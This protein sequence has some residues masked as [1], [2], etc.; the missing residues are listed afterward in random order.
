TR[1]KRDHGS[2]GNN[3][4]K[5]VKDVG[6]VSK[7]SDYTKKKKVERVG[8]WDMTNKEAFENPNGHPGLDAGYEQGKGE[9]Y[10]NLVTTSPA[11]ANVVQKK[12]A[13]NLPDA[14]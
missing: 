14:S 7:S 3:M 2:I 5:H 4:A 8:G 9:R 6:T 1:E 12:G 11:K 13:S 10:H